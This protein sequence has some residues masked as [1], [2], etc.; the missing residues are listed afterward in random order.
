MFAQCN[1][2]LKTNDFHPFE[3][4]ISNLTHTHTR[5]RV[6]VGYQFQY[7]DVFKSHRDVAQ[8]CIT[9]SLY[10]SSGHT[11]TQARKIWIL[12]VLP[13]AS[14]ANTFILYLFVTH[15]HLSL[16]QLFEL[17]CRAEYVY[18]ARCCVS[19]SYRN[20]KRFNVHVK[21]TLRRTSSPRVS[22]AAETEEE[23]R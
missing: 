14:S 16:A 3:C 11:H 13:A 22:S 18:R 4:S 17:I 6:Q 9:L 5:G 8:K 15:T 21:S 2:A 23:T 7:I 12:K 10:L 20:E 19:K 1:N